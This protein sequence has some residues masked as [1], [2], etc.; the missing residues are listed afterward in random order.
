LIS[1][2]KAQFGRILKLNIP[3]S[4]TIANDCKSFILSDEGREIIKRP[5]W[6]MNNIQYNA[7]RWPGPF[8]NLYFWIRTEFFK[9]AKEIDIDM[10]IPYYI[11]G[12]VNIF[13]K[14]DFIDWHN[15]M[16]RYTPN[17]YHGVFCVNAPEDSYTQYRND[18][19]E[20][21]D[22]IKSEAGNC[23]IICDMTT[24][25]KSTENKSDE[26]RITLAFDIITP[27]EYNG[28]WKHETGNQFI[29]FI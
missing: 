19:N 3:N 13:E 21:F 1:D 26:P 5:H 11:H 9:Y 12:W 25:H 7:F 6:V 27:S 22:E 8:A 28:T 2:I 20:I 4:V 10:T 18:K 16:D 17:T 14:G 24:Y 29:P 15:H 23:H